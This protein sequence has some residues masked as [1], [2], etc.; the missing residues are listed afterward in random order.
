M[1]S[2]SSSPS[3]DHAESKLL[4]P[5]LSVS[6]TTWPLLVSFTKIF[7]TRVKEILVPSGDQAGRT[8]S[9]EL[10]VT[11]FGPEPLGRIL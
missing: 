9:V 2:I 8:S 4:I 1:Y 11:F 10:K 7:S 3:G 6:R 5:V